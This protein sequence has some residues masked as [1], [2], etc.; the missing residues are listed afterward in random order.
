MFDAGIGADSCRGA[1][2]R[3][4]ED[5]PVALVQVKLRFRFQERHVCLE[6]RWEGPH[7]LPVAAESV[8]HDL[9][10]TSN[11][12]GQHVSPEVGSSLIKPGG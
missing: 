10:A 7:V 12:C 5:Q 4:C 6:V 3:A 8:S 2:L 1:F 9:G 11:H